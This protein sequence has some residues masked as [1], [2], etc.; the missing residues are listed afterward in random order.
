[1]NFVRIAIVAAFV[2]IGVALS[3]RAQTC[4]VSAPARPPTPTRLVVELPPDGGSQGC[5][6]V[7]V[8]PNGA[9][10]GAYA[11]SN[12]KCATAVAMAKQAASIDNG[13]ADGGAP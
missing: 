5:T 6:I 11:V 4:I 2:S 9:P 7:A 13:W 8:L 12:A 1:M 10:P 3:A